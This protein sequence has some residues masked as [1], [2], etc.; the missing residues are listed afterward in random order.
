MKRG[1][2]VVELSVVSIPPEGRFREKKSVM[3]K[4]CCWNCKYYIARGD[5]EPSVLSN[6]SSNV[7]VFSENDNDERDWMKRASPTPPGY[8]CKYYCE[9]FY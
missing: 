9:R 8:V 2:L 3:A 6:A 4:D 5:H 1:I 7:C